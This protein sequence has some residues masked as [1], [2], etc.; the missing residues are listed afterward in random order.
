LTGIDGEEIA[1]FDASIFVEDGFLQDV[2]YNADTREL[3]FTWNI[4]VSAEGEDIVYKTDVVNVADLVDTYTSGNGLELADGAFSIKLASDSENFLSVDANGL[5]LSGIQSAIDAAKQAAIDDAAGKYYTEGEVDNLLNAKANAADVYTKS[6]VYTKGEADQAIADKISE[7]NGGESA[8][9]VLGQLN[10]YKKI[11]NMEVWGD[12][13]GA[14]TGENGD[15]RIDILSTKVQALENVGA[16]ANV[17]ESVVVNNGDAEVTQPHK[18]TA[19][20][21]DKTV[22]LNDAALQTAIAEAKQVGTDAGQVASEAKS[23]ASQNAAAIQEHGTKIGDLD[24]LTKEHNT[25][26]ANL[27]LADSTH[28]GELEALGGTVATHDSDIATLKANKADTS[29]TDGLAGRITTN[30]NAIKTLN[31]TTIPSING[32]IAKKADADEVY[33]KT[34]IGTIEADKTLVQ[35]IADAKG[36]ATYDDTEV[37]GLIADNADAITAIYHVEGE[38][39]SGI[40]ATEITRVEGLVSAETG[41]AQG[42]EAGLA[43][44]LDTVEAFWKEALRDGDEKNVIDTLKEIQEYIESD[45]SGAAAMAASIKSNSDAIT[46]IYSVT[47]DGTESGILVTKIAGVESSIAAINDTETGI[48]AQAKKHT[49]DSIGSLLVKDVDDKTIKLNEGKA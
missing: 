18:L 24:T 9:E 6:E 14:G 31:D 34:E 22:T 46:A 16:Q 42:V 37:R 8:G 13:T 10:A 27:E 30:E 39:K 35:M 3:T 11:V 21:S 45:E 19:T 7:V 17:I 38:T 5:K 49:N 33:T 43:G 15:S 48:L 2:S 4:I 44:R 20:L 41:R 28:T 36:E 26:I 1:G 12:E 25:K 32:E 40:L 29:V 23:A 47:E